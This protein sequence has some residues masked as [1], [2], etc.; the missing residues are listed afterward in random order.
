MMAASIKAIV[1]KTAQLNATKHFF[2][3]VLGFQIKETST[4][5]FV[6]HSKG[7]RLV[8]IESGKGFEIELFVNDK[9]GG[10]SKE[11]DLI[12]SSLVSKVAKTPMALV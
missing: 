11:I 2:K 12:Y 7:I 9:S 10:F 6:V 8:F 4:Q 1:F 3:T 5:H